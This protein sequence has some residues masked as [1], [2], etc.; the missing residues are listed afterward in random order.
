MDNLRWP[1]DAPQEEELPLS[2]MFPWSFY[3]SALFPKENVRALI[4]A[5]D[6]E[7][8]RQNRGV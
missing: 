6:F 4:E 7:G 5:V 8:T 2:K 3:L 1:L